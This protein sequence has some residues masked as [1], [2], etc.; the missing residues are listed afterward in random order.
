MRIWHMWKYD[1][2]Y[3]LQRCIVTYVVAE[4]SEGFIA[5]ALNLE[6]G[7]NTPVTMYIIACH[8]TQRTSIRYKIL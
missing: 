1:L 8:P 3:A 5:C 4:N 6:D 2:S 7:S